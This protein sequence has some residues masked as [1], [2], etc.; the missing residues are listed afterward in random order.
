MKRKKNQAVRGAASLIVAMTYLFVLAASVQAYPKEM[1]EQMRKAAI[2]GPWEISVRIDSM[3]QQV[4]FPLNVK[5]ENK[6]EKLEK[7][8]PV[9]GTPIKIKIEEY[10][11]DLVWED[12]VK[13]EPDAAAIVRLAFKGPDIDRKMWLDTSNSERKS[14]TSSIGGL[15]LRKVSGSEM[16][17]KLRSAILEGSAP[18]IVKVW[19][20]EKSEPLEYVVDTSKTIE[21]PG[22]KYKL[23]MLEYNP[24][25]SIDTMTREVTKGSDKPVNPS[26]KVSIEDGEKTTEQW[27]WSK[28][29]SLPHVKYDLPLRVEFEDFDI[30]GMNGNYILFVTEDKQSELFVFVDGKVQSKKVDNKSQYPLTNSEY[31][32]QIEKIYHSAVLERKW[33]NNSEELVNPAVIAAIEY[34]GVSRQAVLEINKP[35]HHSVDSNM[36]VLLYKS[37][38]QAA[39]P[40][41]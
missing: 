5:D 6:P 20:D 15:A 30:T 35:F 32:F 21:I 8:L 24:H 33:K 29:P 10:L 26:L 28:F 25:Y 19:L 27:L 36:M 37:K 12:I 16:L 34:S 7:R 18:G 13:E 2:Q 39:N 17:K 22:T 11:P 14:V 1:K 40:G 31:S 38:A 41:H 4:A 23:K 3:E 9:M